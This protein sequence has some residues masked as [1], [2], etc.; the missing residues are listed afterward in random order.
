M[1]SRRPRA[2]NTI[3]DFALLSYPIP[4]EM[5]LLSA[6][7]SFFGW[8]Q[9]SSS[10]W[11]TPS[12]EDVCRARAHLKALDLPTELV[13]QILDFA[14]Y[15]PHYEITASPQHPIAASARGIPKS[16]AA[17]CLDAAVFDNTT[18]HAIRQGGEVPK[19]KS[20]EFHMVSRDQGWTSENTR[21]TYNTSSWLEV[22]I[23]RSTNDEN[24][25]PLPARDRNKV[26]FSP[27]DFHDDVLG[28]GWALV[29]RPESAQQGPQ[30]G[31]GDFGWYL[32]GNRVAVGWNEYRVLW[33]EDRVEGNEGAGSGSGFLQELKDGDR[34]LV[35]ARAKVCSMIQ[36]FVRSELMDNSG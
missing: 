12:Y 3:N 13:L 25:H 4:A 32:Q 33:A 14:Q 11:S 27:S 24:T 28:D 5:S 7:S 10:T 18:V 36:V 21:G 30:G 8:N 17:L 16:H 34:I 1:H 2:L 15:W 31:E 19:I 26:F 9:P 6:V 20:V 29:K 23:L 22:S 35:W